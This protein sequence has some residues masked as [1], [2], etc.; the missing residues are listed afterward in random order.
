MQVNKTKFEKNS[1]LQYLWS[2]MYWENKIQ[3]KE[4]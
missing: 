2:Y 4:V 3:A 1:S